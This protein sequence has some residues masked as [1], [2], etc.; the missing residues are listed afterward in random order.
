MDTP[1]R[2]QQRTT[3]QRLRRPAC[4]LH[5][6]AAQDTDSQHQLRRG[7][8]A[9]PDDRAPLPHRTHLRR[10]LPLPPLGRQQRCSALHREGEQEQPVQGPTALHRDTCSSGAERHMAQG[11]QRGGC[12]SFLRCGT[13][14]VG[15][16]TEEL[17]RAGGQ[18]TAARAAGGRRA[19]D[20]AVEP[21]AHRLH[22][23]ED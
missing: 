3:H 11:G 7:L 16:G 10:A 23:R 6:G 13:G 19:A 20:R 5:A 14:A 15:A 9:G 12:E 18:R 1:E 8:C 4:L 2:T 21:R 22:R 17:R